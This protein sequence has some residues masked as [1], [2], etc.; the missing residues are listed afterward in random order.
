[1][2]LTAI[3]EI[4]DKNNTVIGYK[5]LDSLGF[6][7]Q[8]STNE[9]QN[10]LKK[11][12]SIKNLHLDSQGNVIFEKSEKNKNVIPYF[13]KDG[14]TEYSEIVAIDEYGIYLKNTENKYFFIS[15]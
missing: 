1:M 7:A 11:G 15:F 4:F 12:N 13:L 9:V 10:F 8:I 6:A 2:F 5:T 3:S 14:T